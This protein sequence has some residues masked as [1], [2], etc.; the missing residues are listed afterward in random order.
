[1]RYTLLLH[2]TMCARF[3]SL[4][5]SLSLSLFLSLSLSAYLQSSSSRV[6]LLCALHSLTLCSI[7]RYTFLQPSSIG[8]ALECGGFGGGAYRIGGGRGL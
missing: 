6:P 5:L 3:L 1:M 8:L 4:S 7:T 2:F